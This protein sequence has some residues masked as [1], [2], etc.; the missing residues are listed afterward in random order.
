[1]LLPVLVPAML[2][3]GLW[4]NRK[5]APAAALAVLLAL[6]MVDCSECHDQPTYTL[7]GHDRASK[8]DRTSKTQVNTAQSTCTSILLPKTLIGRKLAR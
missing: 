4:R 5:V 6:Y 7:W 1:M 8:P 2:S 3:V